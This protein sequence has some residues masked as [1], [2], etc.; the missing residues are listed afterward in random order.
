MD[1]KQGMRIEY[2][3][4]ACLSIDTGDTKIVT[5]PW[6][7]GSAYCGQ[8]NVFPKPVNTRVLDDC[9]VVLLSHGHEDHFHP[10]TV[11]K[12]PKSARVFYPYA[13]YGG[14]KPYL[15]ELGFRDVT[16]APTDKTIR[17][18][19]ETAV[20]Y[21]VNNLDS[22]IVIESNGQVFVNVNDALHS[23]PPRIVDVFVQHV[24]ER[25]PRIDTVFCGFGGA[26]YFPN[27]IHCPGKNDLEIADAREQMFVHAFCRIVHALNPKVAVPFAADFALLHSSQRWINERRFPRSRIPDYYRQIYGD[28]P[29]TPQI[30]VMYPGD[31]LNDNQLMPYS[32]YRA[33]L[34][35]GTLNHL[36]D[37]QYKE[38]IAAIGKNQWLTEAEIHTLEKQLV[39]NLEHRMGI[40]NPEVLSKIEFSLKVSDIRENPCFVISMKS[41]APRVQ[42]SG[43]PSR[44]S[45]LQIEIPSGILRHSFASEWG[46]DAITIGY[47]C[48][49]YVFQPGIL[50][51]NLDVTCV[52]LLTRI[53]SA[54]QHWKRE[55]LRLARHVF[56]S[57]ITRSLVAKATWN[58]VRGRRPFPDDH[59]E[60]MRPW[61]LRTKCEVCRACDLPVLDE[62]FAKTL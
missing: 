37:D 47:G 57:P 29:A 19:P 14:I 36:I 35:A 11:E 7:Y 25:W 4:H 23:H 26:S 5:D 38:E 2:I 39:Q 43:A 52:Q 46:G 20:T 12:L 59:N 60:K 6:I 53:P 49:I 31:A 62:E 10:P 34:R 51:S 56:S 33:K 28:S 27:T 48:E 3:S 22:I 32:P 55:P 58:R 8:W 61:L 44:E 18:T 13:W 30:H 54:S 15:N 16:E 21:V 41:G 9:Q 24:R 1:E 42:R 40:F 50:Q 17:V 45:I